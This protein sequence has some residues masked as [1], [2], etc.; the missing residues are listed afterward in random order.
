MHTEF[1]SKNLKG[2]DHL[3]DSD[4]YGRIILNWTLEIMSHG[5]KRIYLAQERVQW[6]DSIK[7]KMK[8]RVSL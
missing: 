1:C 7:M 3:E 8:L 5:I 2:R 6:R 4:V